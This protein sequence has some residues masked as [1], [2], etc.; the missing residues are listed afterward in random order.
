MSHPQRYEILLVPA[1]T[2]HRG[3]EGK[4]AEDKGTESAEDEGTESEDSGDEGANENGSGN[5]DSAP[6]VSAA[7]EASADVPRTGASPAARVHGNAIRSAV[8]AATGEMGETGYPRYSGEGM[9][10]DIDPATHTVEALL[11]DGSELDY[12]LSV[13]ISETDAESGAETNAESDAGTSN[14]VPGADTGNAESGT[15]TDPEPNANG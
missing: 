5:T 15:E 1:F 12:G 6:E 8:V 3:E 14:A 13:R 7:Q 11:I 9:V 10:A 4:A 2:D